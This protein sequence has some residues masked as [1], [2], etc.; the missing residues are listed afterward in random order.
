MPGPAWATSRTTGSPSCLTVTE[1]GVP[2]G[3]CDIDT[4]ARRLSTTWRIALRRPDNRRPGRVPRAVDPVETE[5]HRP[6]PDDR[7]EVLV[8]GG[9]G[10]ASS[11]GR[12]QRHVDELGH[13][14]DSSWIQRIGWARSAGRCRR[15]DGRALRS[16]GGTSA[17]CAVVRGVGDE[18]SEPLLGS[19]AGGERRSRYGRASCSARAQPAT[20]IAEAI[21]R[22]AP[23]VARAIARR[24][25][26][27]RERSQGE[28][29][30]RRRERGRRSR[31]TIDGHGRSMTASWPRVAVSSL[32]GRRR[33]GSRHSSH[34]S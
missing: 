19:L 31:S 20:S 11:A 5:R 13:R 28:A 12:E 3:V 16:R 30:E 25:S 23:E 9:Q 10:L 32:S 34:C 27:R 18:T 33:P 6:R 15:R 14:W 21:D 22:H 2:S 8:G 29:D 4:L 24:V 1:A 26:M 7:D 17:G